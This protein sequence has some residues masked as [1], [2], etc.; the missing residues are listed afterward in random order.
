MNQATIPF[1]EITDIPA[2]HLYALQVCNAGVWPYKRPFYKLKNTI[3]QKHG[4]PAGYD[5][6]VIKKKCWNCSGTGW[7]THRQRCRSCGGDGNYSIS[8][9]LLYRYL[10]NGCIYHKPYGELILD[11]VRVFTGVNDEWGYSEFK[12]E[13]FTGEITNTI[14]GIIS[15]KPEKLSPMW[16]Y[17]YLLWHYD[18]PGFYTTL[19]SYLGALQTRTQSKLKDTLRE[20][21]SALQALAK[22]YGVTKKELG[23]IADDD[24]PF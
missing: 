14:D 21:K 22:Y 12:M 24:L 18:R 6:Q 11:K 8:K 3:L 17:F 2:A 16:A 19:G 1:T 23:P 15:H 5:L 9:V 4:H 10:I 13:S 7:F 20:Y